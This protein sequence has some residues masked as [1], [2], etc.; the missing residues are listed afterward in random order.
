[1]QGKCDVGDRSRSIRSVANPAS[2]QVV[3]REDGSVMPYARTRRLPT[4]DARSLTNPRARRDACR[5]SIVSI[6]LVAS[7]LGIACASAVM[8]RFARR[9]RVD[10]G[11]M[12]HGPL[13]VYTSMRQPHTLAWAGRAG[14][15]A[16]NAWGWSRNVGR[17]LTRGWGSKRRRHMVISCFPLSRFPPQYLSPEF[18][19][20]LCRI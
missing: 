12:R 5:V 10:V 3:S 7:Q 15:P 20:P 14:S 4:F 1:M 9:L 6:P 19:F 16:I 18:F 13:W 17:A 8:R 11:H 2:R